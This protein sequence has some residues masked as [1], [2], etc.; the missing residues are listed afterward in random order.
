MACCNTF[1]FDESI[2]LLYGCYF[3]IDVSRKPVEH[4]NEYK[5]ILENITYEINKFE[6]PKQISKWNEIHTCCETHKFLIDALDNKCEQY[7]VQVQ[8]II[9]KFFDT[10]QTI[11]NKTNQHVTTISNVW[12]TKKILKNKKANIEKDQHKSTFSSNQNNKI[13]SELVQVVVDAHDTSTS[14]SP[15]VTPSTS[16]SMSM[17]SSVASCPGLSLSEIRVIDETS[18]FLDGNPRRLKRIMNVYNVARLLVQYNR[19]TT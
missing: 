15:L 4:L 12:N 3:S 17:S 13:P 1:D 10:L 5:D 6:D 16:I 2:K 9:S 11:P 19:H 18:P 8:Q 14:I 7:K